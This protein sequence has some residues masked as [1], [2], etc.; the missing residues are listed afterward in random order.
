MWVIALERAAQWCSPK[1]IGC[2]QPS[3][4]PPP[5]MPPTTSTRRPRGD[6]V[7]AAPRARRVGRSPAPGRTAGGRPAGPAHAA[8]RR[9]RRGQE[10]DARRV[11]GPPA[12]HR[13]RRVAV[14]RSRRPRPPP[15]LARR[16]AARS[17]PPACRS[18]WPSLAVH[19][20]ESVDLLIPALVNALV[21]LDEPVV[22][23]L[24]DLHEVG[25]ARRDRRPRPAAAPSAGRAAARDLH[26]RGPAAAA[27][28]PPPRGRADRDPRGRPRVHRARDGGAAGRGGHRPRARRRARSCGAAPRAGPRACGS[29][30]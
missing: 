1:T 3:G 18:R 16:A 14:A 26:A 24:D 13:T 22:L 9:R 25:D 7:H 10:R 2:P 28:P 23:V 12:V 19:P 17:P 27:G 29:P 4:L 20:A 15:L 5:P 11:G 21:E 30:R 8:R 6:E